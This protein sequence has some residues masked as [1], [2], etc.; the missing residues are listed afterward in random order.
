MIMKYNGELLYQKLVKNNI[1]DFMGV[2]LKKC[3]RII[4][5]TVVR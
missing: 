3:V 2:V 4:C 1:N 5:R